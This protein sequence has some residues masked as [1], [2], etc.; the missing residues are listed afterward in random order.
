MTE[1]TLPLITFYQGGQTYQHSL[2]ETIAPLI[3]G[4]DAAVDPL[5]RSRT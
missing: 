4:M 3:W 1:H 2:L 5:A